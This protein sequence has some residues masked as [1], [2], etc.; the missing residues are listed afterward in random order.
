MA[1][2]VTGGPEVLASLFK[3]DNPKPAEG[4]PKVR[5]SLKE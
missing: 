1:D 2:Y 5:R 3:F 4:F